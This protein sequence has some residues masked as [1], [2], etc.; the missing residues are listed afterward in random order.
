MARV[1]RNEYGRE[2]WLERLIF[3]EGT[4][5][6]TNWIYTENSAMRQE[7]ERLGAIPQQEMIC[8]LL[9]LDGAGIVGDEDDTFV[10]EAGGNQKVTKAGYVE[11]FEDAV[12]CI[13]KGLRTLF[14]CSRLPALQLRRVQCK[15]RPRYWYTH[16][17][18]RFAFKCSELGPEGYTS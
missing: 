16:K 12:E 18:L 6:E 5:E 7:Q 10:T 8:Q 4:K 13:C 3:E 17:S 9:R 11:L 14:L 1:K 2:P 15:R